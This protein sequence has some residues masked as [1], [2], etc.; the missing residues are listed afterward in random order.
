MNL[1]IFLGKQYTIET[2]CFSMYL[3]V[4]MN[5]QVRIVFVSIAMTFYISNHLTTI[6]IDKV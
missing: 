3:S 6:S 2:H 1:D 4:S 5:V